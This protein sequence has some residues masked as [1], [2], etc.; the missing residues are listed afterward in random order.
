MAVETM[1]QEMS[2]QEILK[3]ARR[4]M[5]LG[6]TA[7]WKEGK[8]SKCGQEVDRGNF[9]QLCAATFLTREQIEKGETI[10]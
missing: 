9:C 10:N 8:C 4:A 6:E 7:E 3:Q 1:R 2:E 5:E